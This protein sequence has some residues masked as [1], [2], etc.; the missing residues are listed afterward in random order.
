MPDTDPRKLRSVFLTRLKHGSNG[1]PFSDAQTAWPRTCSVLPGSLKCRIGPAPANCT[2]PA[3]PPSSRIRPAPRVPS[4][5]VKANTLPDTNLRA[6][7]AF[8]M[9]AHA[10]T[11]IAPT[12]TAPTTKR[13]SMLQLQ[14]TE[15][16]QPPDVPLPAAYHNNRGNIGAGWLVKSERR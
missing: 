1:S 15:R 6:S 4:K 13:E 14:L 12:A 9:P 7:S 5:Q 10:G 8:I 11:I 2:E 16:G 3:A